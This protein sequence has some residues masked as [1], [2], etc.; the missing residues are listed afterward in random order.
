MEIKRNKKRANG[1]TLTKMMIVVGIVSLLAQIAIPSVLQARA[2]SS[3]NTCIANLRQID[4]AK[5]QWATENM[6]PPTSEPT[7]QELSFYLG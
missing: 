1:F 2:T 5:Q 6:R 3:R 4:S 7:T